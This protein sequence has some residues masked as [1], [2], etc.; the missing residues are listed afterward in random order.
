MY[1]VAGLIA[2]VVICLRKS[3]MLSIGIVKESARCVHAMPTIL[4][5]PVVQSVALIV[6][7]VVW[8]IYAVYLASLGDIM[9]KTVAD[10]GVEGVDVQYRTFEYDEATQQYAW[11]LLFCLYW[12]F[13]FIEAVGSMVVARAV[14]SWYFVRDK[15][16]IGT[17]TVLH[18]MRQVI[19]YHLGTCAFGSLIIAIVSLIRAILAYIQKQVEEKSDDNKFVKAVGCMLQ[20]CFWCLEQCIRFINKHAYIQ[21]AIFS[22]SFCVS[23]RNG[24]FLVARNAGRIGAVSA[25]SEVVIIFGKIFITATTGL[26]SYYLIEANLSDDLDSVLV[27]VIFIMIIA[28]FVASLF[29]SIF[30]MAVDT[31]LECFVA[32]EEMFNGDDCYAEKDLK[33]WID[34]NG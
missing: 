26:I 11:F 27:P 9:V 15:S 34:N 13:Y 7:L 21:T 16:T 4:M 1:V 10:S 23:A 32:D 29:F 17:T 20:C 5:F 31:I 25:V 33:E 24:F 28:Y 19:T 14:A 22:T 6:F 3:I 18:S 2:L 12:T 8:L 30:S